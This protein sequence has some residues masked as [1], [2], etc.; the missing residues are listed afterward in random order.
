MVV[1]GKKEGTIYIS[2]LEEARIAELSAFGVAVHCQNSA[3]STEWLIKLQQL[4]LAT[5]VGETIY[6]EH[7]GE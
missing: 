5:S 7:C 1:G 3:H 6:L 2:R 4:N